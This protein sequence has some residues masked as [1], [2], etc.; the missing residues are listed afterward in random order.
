MVTCR[1][2]EEAGLDAGANPIEPNNA[3]LVALIV[4]VLGVAHKS[5]TSKSS[6]QTRSCTHTHRYVSL[7]SQDSLATIK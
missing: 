1:I 2:Q 7:V 6:E 3:R 4:D 5:Q